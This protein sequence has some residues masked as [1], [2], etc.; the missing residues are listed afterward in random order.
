[1]LY[2]NIYNDSSGSSSTHNSYCG[3]TAVEICNN[4]DKSTYTSKLCSIES[5][6]LQ[7]K[8]KIELETIAINEILCECEVM[9]SCSF[10]I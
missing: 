10:Y 4:N 1:M 2:E 8:R 3:T 7:L 6:V 9:V 5:N